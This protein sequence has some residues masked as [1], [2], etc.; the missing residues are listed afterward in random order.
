MCQPEPATILFGSPVIDAESF[1]SRS[2]VLQ[3]AYGSK[4]SD[5]LLGDAD[6]LGDVLPLGES[7]AAGLL[8]SAAGELVSEAGVLVS[9]AGLLVSEAGVLSSAAGCSRRPPGYCPRPRAADR[10]V[11]RVAVGERGRRRQQGEGG[12]GGRCGDRGH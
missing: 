11:R 5:G 8:V 2:K 1:S 3:S 9:A 10:R 12:D 4:S 7:D 6:G